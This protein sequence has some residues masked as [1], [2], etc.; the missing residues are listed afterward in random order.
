VQI[1]KSKI[2]AFCSLF[3]LLGTVLVFSLSNRLI[4]SQEM[5]LI[6]AWDING[7]N[8]ASRI[9]AVWLIRNQDDTFDL[10]IQYH[11]NSPMGYMYFRNPRP[12]SAVYWFF[13]V[14]IHGSHGVSNHRA[15]VIQD[16]NQV[17][18]NIYNNNMLALFSM[19]LRP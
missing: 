1:K 3:L 15:A 4:P 8:D 12:G 11:D 14:S 7:I 13:D 9:R 10:E 5:R 19:M 17:S 16:E 2:A 18:I 6:N